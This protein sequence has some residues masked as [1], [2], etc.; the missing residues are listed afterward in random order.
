MTMTC[1]MIK[2]INIKNTQKLS[3]P[4]LLNSKK[5]SLRDLQ[6]TAYFLHIGNFISISVDN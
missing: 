5:S 1:L 2:K 4:N 6:R 3:E